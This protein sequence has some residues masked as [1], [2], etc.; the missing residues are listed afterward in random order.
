MEV[1]AQV[2]FGR[3]RPGEL[4]TSGAYEKR[5][6]GPGLAGISGGSGPVPSSPGKASV[7][8]MGFLLQKNKGKMQ[9]AQDGSGGGEWEE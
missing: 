9:T 7:L 1:T 5:E 6:E 4:S 8:E 2:Y 3:C